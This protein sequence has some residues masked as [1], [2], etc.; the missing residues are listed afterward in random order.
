[1]NVSEQVPDKDK[2][3]P[4]EVPFWKTMLS[5]MRASFGVQS[6]KNKERDFTGGSVKTF[7]AAALI[8]TTVFVLT[9]VV[10]VSLVLP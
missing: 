4:S 3:Q 9:L 6:R 7:V 5:V 10:I 2:E 1:M 8:F